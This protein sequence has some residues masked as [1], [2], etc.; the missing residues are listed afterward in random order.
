M[1]TLTVYNGELIAGGG[2]TTAGGNPPSR[3]ARWNGATWQPLDSGMNESVY[4]LTVYNGELIAGGDFTTAGGNPAS[5]IARWNGATWQPLASGMNSYVEALTVYP[6]APGQAGEL[7]A[8]GDFATA[9]G[10]VSAYWARWDC[11]YRR[12]D[13]NCDGSV[14]FG[15]INPF[16]L[17]L[18]N[19][20]TYAQT[21]PDCDILIGDMNCDG[22]ADFGDI[23]PFVACLSNGDCD[24]P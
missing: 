13:L 17:A 10:E 4:A 23:N 22:S 11:P 9:G 14:D 24:C 7:I 5:R 21:Y 12:G 20:S 19:P 2:F 18:S 15:D 6:G 1:A 8:G 16:V 3:I